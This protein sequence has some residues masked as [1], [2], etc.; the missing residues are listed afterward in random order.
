[1]GKNMKNHKRGGGGGHHH[2]GKPTSS[3]NRHKKVEVSFNATDRHEYLTGFSKRKKE[4]RAFGLAMQKVKDREAKVE[5]RKERREA[6]LEKI[7][8]IER[9]KRA[10]RRGLLE[11]SDDDDNDNDGSDDDDNDGSINNNKQQQQ[12]KELNTFQDEHTT[13]QFGGLVSVTTTFGIPS[14]DDDD[15]DDDNSIDFYKRV[16]HGKH[17]IDTEQKRAADVNTFMEQ[18]KSNM[19]SKKKSSNGGGKRGGKKGQH[20]AST[21]SGMGNAATLK[22]AQKTLRKFH[23]K[24]GKRG[25]GF[26]GGDERGGGKG[27]K[28][29]KGRR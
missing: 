7:E 19:P 13:T 11:G 12:Q 18:V 17:H 2:K 8:D 16:K 28:K 25:G 20:G 27:G 1:M 23:A 10:L 24:N 14:D 4:R 22:M 6:Q 3:F 21:M 5:E 15:D 9:N 29:R 26:G